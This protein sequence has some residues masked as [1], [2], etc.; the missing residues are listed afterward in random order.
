MYRMFP[1]NGFF[2]YLW[3]R[4]M[5]LIQRVYTEGTVFMTP[6]VPEPPLVVVQLDE[7]V[8]VEE[9][10]VSLWQKHISWASIGL[11]VAIELLFNWKY[12]HKKIVPKSYNE[13]SQKTRFQFVPIAALC[14]IQREKLVFKNSLCSCM[15]EILK[16]K[17]LSSNFND[18]TFHLR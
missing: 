7:P 1:E 6:A 17:S 9:L 15:F 3:V 2:G 12:C 10:D 4:W 5:F 18:H 16:K 14:N 11:F 13:L 8:S